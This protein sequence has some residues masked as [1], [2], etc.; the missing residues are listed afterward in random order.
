VGIVG[1]S[2]GGFIMSFLGES[3]VSGFNLYSFL[4]AIGGAVVLI[5]IV[6]LIRR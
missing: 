4:V 1:V 6:K 2:L 3:G 5:C